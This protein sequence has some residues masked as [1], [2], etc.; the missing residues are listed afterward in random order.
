MLSELLLS[1]LWTNNIDLK[2]KK[3]YSVFREMEMNEPRHKSKTSPW[4]KSHIFLD[5]L[6]ICNNMEK[7]SKQK[8]LFIVKLSLF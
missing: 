4:A 7:K 1:I 2:E 6:F 3:T 5:T 8:F